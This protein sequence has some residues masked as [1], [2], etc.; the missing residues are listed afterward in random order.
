VTA[1]SPTRKI[2]PVSAGSHAFKALNAL[3]T[4][5]TQ[6]DARV[7]AAF[8]RSAYLETSRG[9]ACLGT[10][11][12]GEGPLN[13]LVSSLPALKVGDRVH[14]DLSQAR[15]WR[16]APWPDW[17][18]E[19]TG[20]SLQ[21]LHALAHAATPTEGFAFLLDAA[22]AAVPLSA[23]RSATAALAAWIGQAQAGL[24]NPSHLEAVAGLVG[25]GPG[26][27]PAGDD[28]LG[29]ALC[30]LHACGQTD[31]AR[32]LARCVMPLAASNTSRISRAHLACAAE[33]E[34]GEAVARILHALLSGQTELEA[35]LQAVAAV[36][37][38][39]GWDALAGI[40]LA[41]EA[42]NAGPASARVSQTES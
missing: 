21:A 3:C 19:R 33:G 36:G 1:S 26:L 28:L 11:S 27:T 25:L 29:G 35:P 17:R 6:E 15:V 24:T 12:L 34:C 42:M 23:Q 22:A 37:H 30:A 4:L 40:V 41:L 7:L 10:L 18:P 20:A 5:D 2:Q 13:A 39:S 14:V 31:R 8:A 9:L 32:A 38:T 16:A